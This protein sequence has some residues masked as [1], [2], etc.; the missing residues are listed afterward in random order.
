MEVEARGESLP[1]SSRGMLYA[2]MGAFYIVDS[3]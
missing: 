2:R 1:K 3:P